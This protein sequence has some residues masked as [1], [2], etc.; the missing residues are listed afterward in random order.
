MFFLIIFP[1]GESYL[2]ESTRSL[3][4]PG[5]A[6]GAIQHIQGQ[7]VSF[8]LVSRIMRFVDYRLE[9]FSSTQPLGQGIQGQVTVKVVA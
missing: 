6:I 2:A 7:H 8:E 3:F 4:L 9:K 1:I 5:G